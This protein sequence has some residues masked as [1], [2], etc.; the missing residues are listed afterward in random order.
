M[1]K[2]IFGIITCILLCITPPATVAVTANNLLIDPP[3]GPT[4]G[5][6]GVDYTVCFDLPDD[7]D[8]KPYYVMWD[9]GDGLFTSWIGP[10]SAGETVCA[11]HTWTEPGNYDIRV[12]IKDGCGNEYWS[13]P[14]TIT[15]VNVTELE[16]EV[17]GGLPGKIII[18]NIGSETAYDVNWS[19]NI[20]GGV[21]G[22][23]N[24]NSKGSLSLPLETGNEKNVLWLPIG[25]GRLEITATACAFNAAE[26]QKI[27]EGFLLLFFVIIL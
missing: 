23:V 1:K 7:P 24:Y 20:S 4:E 2:K 9:W 8:C 26:V 3:Y 6:V 27:S 5:L 14:W 21:F 11:I 25:F 18:R 13:D 19:V 12:K 22:F 15:I 16:I 10:Y 17:K